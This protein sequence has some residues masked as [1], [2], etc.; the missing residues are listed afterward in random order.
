MIAS[1]DRSR[2]RGW[3]K[4]VIT[5]R[6]MKRAKDWIAEGVVADEGVDVGHRTPAGDGHHRGGGIGTARYPKPWRAHAALVV[7]EALRA[8]SMRFPLSLPVSDSCGPRGRRRMLSARD[9]WPCR[10][11]RGRMR[12]RAPVSGCR[13]CTYPP[14]E[15]TDARWRSAICRL[16]W[17]RSSRWRENEREVDAAGLPLYRP[18]EGT[19]WMGIPATP[20][21]SEGSAPGAV[22]A[23]TVFRIDSGRGGGYRRAPV[24]WE[25]T[26]ALQVSGLQEML[27]RNGHTPLDPVGE[28]AVRVSRGEARTI[29]FARAIARRRPSV[30]L[31]DE[32][33]L[34]TGRRN[35][36][37][38]P[39]WS[40][41]GPP[42]PA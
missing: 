5:R 38:V 32:A 2:P 11:L 3:R 13:R 41:T 37:C 31:I 24:S 4:R 17:E 21:S 35:G 23:A 29:A 15:R 1:G 12:R 6:C 8:R 27:Q 25:A 30:L 26:R 10:I 33:V 14:H 9:G 18:G 19:I 28:R 16:A 20:R 34:S 42:T 22:N 40:G 7:V 36:R 39:T